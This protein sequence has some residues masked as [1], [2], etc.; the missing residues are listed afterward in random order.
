MAQA[1]L[2]NLLAN[3]RPSY[4]EAKPLLEQSAAGLLAL[5]D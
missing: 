1:E 2:S 4:G 3:R 5:G